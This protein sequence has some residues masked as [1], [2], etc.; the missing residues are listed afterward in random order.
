MITL[1][2]LLR[3]HNG[4]TDLKKRR[5]KGKQVQCIFNL[6]CEIDRLLLQNVIFVAKC[7][8]RNF[9]Y[10]TFIHT[11]IYVYVYVYRK[12]KSQQSIYFHSSFY[13]ICCSWERGY[14]QYSLIYNIVLLYIYFIWFTPIF[15]I[16][17]TAIGYSKS[18]IIKFNILTIL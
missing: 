4:C 12:I 8:V 18:I 13:N 10:Y 9:L 11:D 17:S 2:R 7:T 1:I 6:V 14:E 3:L 16:I 5:I 15:L